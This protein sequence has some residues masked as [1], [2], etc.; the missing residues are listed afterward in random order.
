MSHLG[1]FGLYV[2]SGLGL[3]YGFKESPNVS[4]IFK[5]CRRKDLSV[6]FPATL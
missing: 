1:G 3:Y 4:K 6:A 2:V 5:H